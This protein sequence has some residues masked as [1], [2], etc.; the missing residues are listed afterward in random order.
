MTAG[1]T[2]GSFFDPANMSTGGFLSNVDCTIAD[3]KIITHEDTPFDPLGPDDEDSAYLCLTFQPDETDSEARQEYYRLGGI[4]KVTPSTDGKRAVFAEG[5]KLNKSTKAGLFFAALIN[6]GFPRQELP[7]DNSVGFLVG[8]HGHVEQIPMDIKEG[9]G[10]PRFAKK[11]GAGP[12]TVTVIT[13]LLEAKGAK[14]KGKPAAAAKTATKTA[15]P[16]TNGH[17]TDVDVDTLV[18]RAVIDLMMEKGEALKRY[19]PTEMMKRLTD[20][21]A[22]S[23]AFKMVG[24]NEWLAGGPWAYDAGSG[25]LTANE[26]TAEF[27]AAQ[28]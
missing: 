23:A 13:K 25:T 1:Q 18:Q 24:N 12:P 4:S 9:T 27:M 22:K 10:K 20:K 16:A 21:D 8:I 2:T 19:L 15:A 7:V 11:E 5:S 3:A 6:A 28:A 26:A 17:A 14:A